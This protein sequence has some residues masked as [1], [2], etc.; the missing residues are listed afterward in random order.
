M[1]NS[2]RYIEDAF[3]YSGIKNVLLPDDVVW[4]NGTFIGCKNLE[5]VYI[6]WNDSSSEWAHHI[7]I[8]DIMGIEIVIWQ[9]MMRSS[10]YM[11]STH[12]VGVPEIF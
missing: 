10:R 1:P 5:N 9:K 11:S 4:L 2:L 12:F 8:W 3:K 7:Y 6:N